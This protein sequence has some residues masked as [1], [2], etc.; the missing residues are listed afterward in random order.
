MDIAKE[1]I[2]I[3]DYYGLENRKNQLVEEMAEL[4]QAICKQRRLNDFNET[5][6]KTAEEIQKINENFIEEIADV[7]ICLQQVLYLLHKNREINKWV[8]YK[9]KRTKL[10]NELSAK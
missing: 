4:T 9:I 3:A 10:I 7:Y 6:L 5:T 8:E 2:N 1:I